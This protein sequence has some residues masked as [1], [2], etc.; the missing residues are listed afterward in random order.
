MTLK[1]LMDVMFSP[2]DIQLCDF[3]GKKL[4]VGIECRD[5]KNCEVLEI[6]RGKDHIWVKIDYI[7]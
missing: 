2:Y 6:F 4:A 1:Q 7:H 5:Y 3:Y